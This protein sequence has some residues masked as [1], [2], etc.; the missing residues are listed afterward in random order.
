M[1]NWGEVGTCGGKVS[2]D[3][4]AAV[5]SSDDQPTQPEEV[6]GDK[7][8][9]EPSTLSAKA[10]GN[11]L[12]ESLSASMTGAIKGSETSEESVLVSDDSQLSSQSSKI[13]KKGTR[14]RVTLVGEMND[15]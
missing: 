9:E 8:T 2:K 13:A 12:S 6:E 11:E 7:K 14:M 5:A 15:N 3:I 10:N 4:N 1:S